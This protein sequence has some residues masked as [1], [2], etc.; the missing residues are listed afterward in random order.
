MQE[1]GRLPLGRVLQVIRPAAGG[2]RRHLALLCTGL[3]QQGISVEVAAPRD[4]ELLDA[5]AIPVHFLPITPHPHPLYDLRAS[6]QIACL[7]RHTNLIHAH[8]LRGAWIGTIAT[9][10]VQKPLI[11]TAHNLVPLNAGRLARALLRFVMRRT[12]AL[13]A[14]S[15]AVAEGLIPYG[16][17]RARVTVIPNGIDLVPFD[18]PFDRS[19][20]LRDLGLPVE[21]RIVAAVGRLSPEKGFNT[22]IAAAPQLMAGAPNVHLVL[23]GEGPERTRLEVQARSSGFSDRIRLPGYYPDIPSLLRASEV[24]AI[25]SRIEG[26][27]IVALEAMAA[28]KPVVA[29]RVGGLAETVRDGM[30]G[31][32]VPPDDPGALAHALRDLLENETTRH[33]MG[34]AGRSLVEREYTVAQMVERTVAVYRGCMARQEPRPPR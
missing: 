9:R 7:A 11:V 19:L 26:Q 14:V 27:G 24:I 25:P 21:A 3:T 33:Q 30:T 34:T 17:D 22:L 32:L 12:C 16:L 10:L 13:I 1:T 20:L 6:V 4:F 23:A 8:G 29:S 15:Q 28:C 5:T 2:M 18:T 31:I